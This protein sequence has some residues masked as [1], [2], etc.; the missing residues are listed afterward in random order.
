M[1]I[2][3][4][5]LLNTKALAASLEEEGFRIVSGGTDNHLI[6]VDLSTACSLNGREAERLLDTYFITCNKNTIPNDPLPP[7][8]ASGIRLGAAAMTT[9]GWKEKDFIKIGKQIAAIL[10]NE[11]AI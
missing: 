5:V 6:L 3:K 1:N 10:K 4:Q 2:K 11:Q 7:M 8:K 9:K